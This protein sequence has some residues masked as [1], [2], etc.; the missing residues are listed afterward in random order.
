MEE[1]PHT[2]A[3]LDLLELCHRTV[4]KP[5]NNSFHPF[6]QHYHL[7][8][9]PAEGKSEF[10]EKIERIFA[11]NGIAYELQEN[12]KIVRLAPP[13]LRES[14][15]NTVYQ[16]GDVHLD[17]MLEMARK[18][19]LDPN[20]STRSE[21]LE[22]LWDAWE[23]LKTIN[24]PSD[25]KKSVGLLL[26]EAS[27]EPNFRAMLEREATELTSI[28]NRFMIRHTESDKIH[29]ASMN[30]VDYLFHR[31]FALIHL[32]LESRDST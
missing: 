9:D 29:V 17:S 32:L 8:F 7:T 25:K 1:P 12:G 15:Q 4:V 24:S 27:D 30:H 31:M 22:K 20:P 26:N 14:I 23:R 13:I 21:S 3:I 10:R 28:G 6:F 16:T 5:I 11:R 19:Y 2:L 18:K